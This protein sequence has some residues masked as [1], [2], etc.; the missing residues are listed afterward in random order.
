MVQTARRAKHYEGPARA[1]FTKVPHTF[2]N[3]AAQAGIG[4]G[5][6]ALFVQLS[7]HVNRKSGACHP[8]QKRLA[9]LMACCERTVRNRLQ[10]LIDARFVTVWRERKGGRWRVLRYL[11]WPLGSA[12]QPVSPP[13]DE[14]RA[15]P[16]VAG[17]PTECD[18]RPSPEIDC[19]P[20]MTICAAP[21]PDSGRDAG[22]GHDQDKQDHAGEN[23]M[24][25]KLMAL[26]RARKAA[27]AK[28]DASR[29]KRAARCDAPTA[30]PEP[31]P[32]PVNAPVFVKRNSD[33][34][35]QMFDEA[36]QKHWP[37]MRFLPPWTVKDK[38]IAKNLIM[39]YADDDVLPQMVDTLWRDR[40]RMMCRGAPG[41]GFMWAVQSRLY[42]EAITAKQSER[43]MQDAE[44]DEDGIQILNKAAYDR[45]RG[46]PAF[47]AEFDPHRKRNVDANGVFE[48]DL[49]DDGD[50]A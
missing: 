39:S 17:A 6:I 8:G 49:D 29:S 35:R 46:S 28:A 5:E 32:E 9:E 12:P 1:A 38:A 30:R 27:S 36:R 47:R 19:K 45:L 33:W 21:E 14:S 13:A 10:R 23:D 4:A 37:S 20:V 3:R 44:F 34:L 18:T 24:N 31:E 22:A 25:E 16:V 41:P 48:L 2:L 7:A 42:G 50:V 43:V 15:A 40:E 26:A 11:L